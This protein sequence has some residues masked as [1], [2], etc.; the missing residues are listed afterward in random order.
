MNTPASA[1]HAVANRLGLMSVKQLATRPGMKALYRV[2]IYYADGY[3]RNS[4]GTLRRAVLDDGL[5]DVV[6]E[7]L[8]HHKPLKHR[9][10]PARAEKLAN[11]LQRM[12]FDKMGD[13]SGMETYHRTMWLVERAVGNFYHSVLFAPQRLEQPYVSLVNAIDAYLP[14]S[15]REVSS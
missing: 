2:T 4:V 15:I 7:G 8:F 3:A 10:D 11:A 6:Y 12:G 1:L 5:L 9:I 13:Q 14:E